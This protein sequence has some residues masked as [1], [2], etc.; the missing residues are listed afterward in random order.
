MKRRELGWERHP[1][2]RS[3]KC[4]GPGV[5][6]SLALL[7]WSE[8]SVAVSERGGVAPDRKAGARAHRPSRPWSGVCVLPAE[9]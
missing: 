9:L 1:R 2:R 7:E 3:S 4:K 5:G 8:T 6:N